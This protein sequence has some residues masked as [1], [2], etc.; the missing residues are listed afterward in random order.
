MTSRHTSI[1][2]PTCSTVYVLQLEHHALVAC[3]KCFAI[4]EAT[5]PGIPSRPI[6]DDWSFMQIG[7]TGVY[8]KQLFTI[9]GRIRVQLRNDYKNF[10]SAAHSQGQCLWIVESFASFSVFSESWAT[11]KGERNKL[12]AGSK[13]K[14]TPD[15][16]V[17]EGEYVEKCEGLTYAGEV[18]PWFFFDPGFFV[19]QG[20]ENKHT[21][22]FFLKGSDVM[23][24]RGEKVP[25][26]RLELKQTLTWHE[27][28]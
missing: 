1:T 22:L 28:E 12:R 20:S 25:A 23:S 6:P 13:I 7:A 4:L 3:K 16:I 26:H 14:G 8:N 9:T 2:C 5:I 21:A 18:G 15:Q 19:V 11:Y 10:W 24:M 27:W 17:L